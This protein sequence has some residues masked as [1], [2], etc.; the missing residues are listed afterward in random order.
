MKKWIRSVRDESGAEL[1]EAALI[2]PMVLLIIA[3]L[4]YLGIYIL[5][6]VTVS[7][8]AQ[9]VAML[10]A[11]EVSYPGYIDMISDP[12]ASFGSSAIELALNSYESPVTADENRVNVNGEMRAVIAI[13]T[14]SNKTSFTAYRFWKK[15]PI[16]KDKLEKYINVMQVLVNENSMVHAEE[17]ATVTLTAQNYVVA[18]YVNVSVEQK[19]VGFGL[20]EF[21]GIKNPTVSASA[22]AAASDI[23]DFVRTTDFVVDTIEMLAQRCGI[24]VK[25]IKSKVQEFRVKFFDADDVKD[26]ASKPVL[27]D[28]HETPAS[29]TPTEETPAD[30]GS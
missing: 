16:Y 13:P 20:L 17:D 25:S 19:L 12:A 4:F 30:E 21:F 23:D 1:I 29:T 14:D 9:K 18:Q 10:A 26:D 2:Y 24:D 28:Q 6:N 5:Q 27:P 7:C 8:Y 3:F 11:R 15:I 22:K